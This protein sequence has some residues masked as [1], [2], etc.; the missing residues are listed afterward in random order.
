MTKKSVLP[1]DAVTL[2]QL[3]T[4]MIEYGDLD[5][6]V[7]VAL[8]VAWLSEHLGDILAPLLQPRPDAP[9]RVEV[10]GDALTYFQ[11]AFTRPTNPYDLFPQGGTAYGIPVV[12]N[13][14]LDA[15]MVRI[16]SRSGD[17]ISESYT[18]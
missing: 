1:D 15:R 18:P 10:G 7:E 5:M 2:R 6:P 17:V 12:L 13:E 11:R 14:E 16:I 9:E 3:I 4:Q 8:T